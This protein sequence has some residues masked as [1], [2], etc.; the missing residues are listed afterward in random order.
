MNDQ[1]LFAGKSIH[2]DLATFRVAVQ[3]WE[4]ASET[5]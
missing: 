3:S 1:G 2:L 4:D 5:L